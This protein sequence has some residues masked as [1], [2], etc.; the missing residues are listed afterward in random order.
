MLT[1]RAFLEG[2]AA[3]MAAPAEITAF[4]DLSV[5]GA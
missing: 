2:A 3:M 4:D 1:R 5:R